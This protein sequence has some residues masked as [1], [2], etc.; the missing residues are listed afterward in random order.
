MENLVA[1]RENHGLIILLLQLG[2]MPWMADSIGS[3]KMIRQH[4]SYLKT[5]K[6]TFMTTSSNGSN[7]T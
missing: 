7:E 5:T 6:I 4:M 1:T 2:L 3:A